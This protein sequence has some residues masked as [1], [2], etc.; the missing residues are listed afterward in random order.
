MARR[1]ET[2]GMLYYADIKRFGELPNMEIEK[3]YLFDNMPK[4]W[5]YP[6]IQPKLIGKVAEIMR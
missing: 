1:T 5:T 2:Y 4:H 3:I 6:N